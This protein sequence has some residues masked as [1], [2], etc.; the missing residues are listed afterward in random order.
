[1]TTSLSVY[2]WGRVQ[3]SGSAGGD[4]FEGG[5][6]L[7]WEH[8]ESGMAPQIPSLSQLEKIS[9][10]DL[11]GA[12]ELRHS[13]PDL[14][15]LKGKQ[16]CRVHKNQGRLVVRDGVLVHFFYRE[17]VSFSGGEKLCDEISNL[18]SLIQAH[19]NEVKLEVASWGLLV[20]YEDGPS[21]LSGLQELISD[22]SFE[23]RAATQAGDSSYALLVSGFDSGDCLV[24]ARVSDSS[25]NLVDYWYYHWIS[26]ESSKSIT[27]GRYEALESTSSLIDTQ[28]FRSETIHGKQFRSVIEAHNKISLDRVDLITLKFRHSIVQDF[29]DLHIPQGAFSEQVKPIA[30]HLDMDA[31]TPTLERCIR[32]EYEIH[33]KA[34]TLM[35]MEV[36]GNALERAEKD[37]KSL[38]ELSNMSYNTLI[39]EGLQRLQWMVFAVSIMSLAVGLLTFFN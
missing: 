38:V 29:R 32:E 36:M 3:T 28:K 4:L 9:P 7:S 33:H 10:S 31:H 34:P 11:P 27:A 30:E 19:L 1:M 39:Q 14:A 18:P 23:I 15:L 37:A 6:L 16:G 26:C 8:A 2:A 24:H 17:H 13:L 25:P 20:E 22:D 21:L 35:L 5:D 12:I